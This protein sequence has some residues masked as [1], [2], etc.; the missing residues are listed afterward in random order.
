MRQTFPAA[1]LAVLVALGAAQPVSAQLNPL[2]VETLRSGA[3][4]RG[5]VD[6]GRPP[7]ELIV[8]PSFDTPAISR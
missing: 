5:L 1:V 4:A 7:R 6:D 2:D 3:Q 8:R